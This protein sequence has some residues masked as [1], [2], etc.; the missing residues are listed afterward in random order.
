M[1]VASLEKKLPRA[2]MEKAESEKVIDKVLQSPE[3]CMKL[4]SVVLVDRNQT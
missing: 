4:L 2:D 3:Q 1:E